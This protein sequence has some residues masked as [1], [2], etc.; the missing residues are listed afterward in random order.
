MLLVSKIGIIDIADC[1]HLCQVNVQ[2]LIDLLAEK[3]KI[4][5]RI[6]GICQKDCN[7]LIIAQLP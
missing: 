1:I 5:D 6:R 3:L 7:V 2:D 4:L